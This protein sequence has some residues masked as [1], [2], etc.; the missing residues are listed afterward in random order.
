MLLKNIY[1]TPE[2]QVI[3]INQNNKYTSLVKQKL[4]SYSKNMEIYDSLLLEFFNLEEQILGTIT[5]FTENIE[6]IATTM[7]NILHVYISKDDILFKYHNMLTKLGK[8]KFLEN[9][10]VCVFPKKTDI[11][12]IKQY[13]RN[14]NTLEPEDLNEKPNW[15]NYMATYILLKESPEDIPEYFRKFDTPELP[16]ILIFNNFHRASRDYDNLY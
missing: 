15:V 4:V 5:W 6:N 12:E 11:L 1:Y 14:P 3:Q 13:F 10:K 7:S 8:D 2:K 9:L 16:G